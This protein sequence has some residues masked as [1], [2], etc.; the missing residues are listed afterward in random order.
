MFR[1]REDTTVV[2]EEGRFYYAYHPGGPSFDEVLGSAITLADFAGYAEPYTSGERVNIRVEQIDLTFLVFIQNGLDRQAD[3]DVRLQ[4]RGLTSDN[5]L[6][7]ERSVPA[8]TEILATI[9]RPVPGASSIQ[10][11]YSVRYR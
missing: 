7:V 5:G 4:L 9:L 10:Y 11:G 8:R 1:G 6:T 3:I 2:P